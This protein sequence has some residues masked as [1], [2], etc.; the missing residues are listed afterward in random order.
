M[1]KDNFH[2]NCDKKGPTITLMRILNGPCVGAFTLSAY[3]SLSYW[4][5]D[6]KAKLFNLTE[7]KVFEI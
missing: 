2:K 5:D 1:R 6:N 4:A 7:N 3:S